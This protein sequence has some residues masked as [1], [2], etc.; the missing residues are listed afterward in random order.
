MVVLL[1]VSEKMADSIW[2]EFQAF[3]GMS[4][5]IAVNRP[6]DLR[7]FLS[8]AVSSAALSMMEVNQ[9]DFTA[10]YFSEL[11]YGSELSMPHAVVTHGILENVSA[12][13]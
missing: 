7:G 13:K 9:K 1:L 3:L 5:T 8:M 6:R 11:F 4:A 12:G 2:L 10:F